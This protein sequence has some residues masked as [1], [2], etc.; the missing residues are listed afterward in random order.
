MNQVIT[1]W[2]KRVGL[3]LNS[4]YLS[5]TILIF[6]AIPVTLKGQ[7][8]EDQVKAA[9]IYHFSR[10]V[11]WPVDKVKG[12]FNICV[13]SSDSSLY[14]SLQALLENR[15]LKGMPVYIFLQDSVQSLN[16]VNVLVADKDRSKNA[17]A[18]YEVTRGENTLLITD[19][20]E[21]PL[22]VM[23]NITYN[24]KDAKISYEINAHNLESE[25]LAFS[26]DL[27]LKGGVVLDM[28]QLYARTYELLTKE[29]ERLRSYQDQ[30]DLLEKR[31]TIT[32]QRAIFFQQKLDS[33]DKIATEKEDQL[34]NLTSGIQ[35]KELMLS[36]QAREMNEQKRREN[37][38]K[39]RLN[40][41]SEN[42]N[43]SR[44]QLDSIN[45]RIREKVG[46]IKSQEEMIT[47]KDEEIVTR[48]LKIT[49]Q[50]KN[51]RRLLAFLALLAGI[52]LI[53]LWAY[54]ARKRM[55]R[56]LE[57]LVDKRTEELKE[58]QEYFQNLF[59]SSPVAIIELELPEN[60]GR[61]IDAGSRQ[62]D[63]FVNSLG[64]L[65]KML[66]FLRSIRV[67]NMNEAA[68]KL[69]NAPGREFLTR[70]LELIVSEKTL[71]LLERAIHAFTRHEHIFESEGKFETFGKGTIDI[72]IRWILLP[73][74]GQQH[75]RILVTFTDI[76]TLKK[77]EAE[78]RDH[79]DNLESLVKERS[80]QILSL[81]QELVSIN[82]AL[83]NQKRQLETT[84]LQLQSTQTQLV[85]AE[86]MA[87]LGMLSAGIA[88]EINNPI[89]FIS[90]G[91]QLLRE[92]I[93]ILINYAYALEK[94]LDAIPPKISS[95]LP[96]LE[97]ECN[98]PEMQSA[99]SEVLM[100]VTEGIERTTEII[101][102]LSLYSRGGEDI[103]THFDVR[104]A[105]SQSLLLLKNRYKSHIE[106]VEEFSDVPEIECIP[107]K[108]SQVFVNLISNSIDAI[109]SS[110]KIFLKVTFSP[111]EK[112][113]ITSIKDTG[114]G[115]Q[116]EAIERIFDPFYTTKEVGKGTGLGL[117]LV[118]QIVKQHNASI[119]CKSNPEKGTE[120]I[121]SWPLTQENI[122]MQNR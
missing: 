87:S 93:N 88:H 43:T 94:N 83:T 28:K 62:T 80:S 61:V 27:L 84:L 114:H 14:H 121:V 110:G 104:K 26:P 107:A 11:S 51:L 17:K 96:P 75:Q 4:L 118:Y 99:I 89:N 44:N 35:A 47:A 117:Y 40:K 16:Q 59:E 108:V 54:N 49:N 73:G 70:Q 58:S 29:G 113:V 8:S 53:L 42:I 76:T 72:I 86:K 30:M 9:L 103:F 67:P 1:G 120:F 24:R 46:I 79:R 41:Y 10:Y 38:L 78:L 81:N 50:Q 15:K 48:D 90:G 64:E 22:Y 105:I 112:R 12:T 23:I 106:V 32:M 55:N 20:S 18:L 111:S 34:N 66:E 25:Q 82:E 100:M 69:F 21:E 33:L 116:Q 92:Q 122:L 36:Q 60:F 6:L 119:E 56:I 68:V 52:A 98:L 71:P 2:K 115:I 77:F 91:N 19:Q 74:F 101:R 97:A 3:F 63:Q 7:Y 57:G 45:S 85:Q 37:E 31:N 13:L 65:N 5:C 39:S 109:P 95:Q 102:S